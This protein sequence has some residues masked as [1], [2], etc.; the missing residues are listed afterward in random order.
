GG[1]IALPAAVIFFG[2]AVTKEI[3]A[4]GSFDIGFYSLPV[5]FQQ[6]PFGQFFGTV[7][8]VALFL[9]GLTSS[10][11]MFTPL[12]LFLQDELGIDRK[13]IVLA[14][15]LV[16]F[17]LM[18]PIVLFMHKGIL[19]ELDYWAGTFFLVLFA[20]IEA[21]V[22]AWIFGMKKGWEE[23]HA[24]ADFQVPRIFYP[25]MKFVTPTYIVAL[26]VWSSVEVWN[27]KL[28]GGD[29]DPYH[30]FARGLIVVV[31]LLLCLGI[32]HA[33]RTRPH[34]FDEVEKG[35]EL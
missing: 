29:Q 28:A 8:F 19:G 35:P 31:G 1:T 10:V 16:I 13:R 4:G 17:I 25:I 3:A 18:Q 9:A 24:G 15:G 2:P 22:F 11:A 34:L 27:T 7:W 12:L 33:W 30:W 23:M 21:V 20:A 26:L 5:I 6:L 32:R 14:L